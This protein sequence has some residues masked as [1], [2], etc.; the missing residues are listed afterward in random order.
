MVMS[1]QIVQ[2]QEELQSA[3]AERDGLLRERTLDAGSETIRA[4]VSALGEERDQLLEMVQG[5]REEKDQM[6]AELEEKNHRVILFVLLLLTV[7]I[8]ERE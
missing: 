7:K 3:I 8:R 6:S 2:L 4:S 1:S 5:L